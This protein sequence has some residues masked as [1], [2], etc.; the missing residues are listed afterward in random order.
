MSIHK[1]N[2]L[3]FVIFTIL[4]LGEGEGEGRCGRGRGSLDWRGAGLGQRR[5]LFCGSRVSLL[6]HFNISSQ[7]RCDFALHESP[8]YIRPNQ[9]AFLSAGAVHLAGGSLCLDTLSGARETEFVAGDRWALNE[10]RVLQTFVANGTAQRP[11]VGHRR[12]WNVL[13]VHL[14][15]ARV[16]ARRWG[17]HL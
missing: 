15:H 8:R 3:Q 1:T 5:W 4:H 14:V 2:S 7:D 6:F 17:R 10:M 12:I 9:G 11:A 16:G 13:G